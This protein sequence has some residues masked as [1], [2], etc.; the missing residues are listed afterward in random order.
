MKFCNLVQRAHEQD[1][2]RQLFYAMRYA[3]RLLWA[4]ILA[5]AVV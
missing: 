1:L 3:Q 2:Q 5:T 4:D